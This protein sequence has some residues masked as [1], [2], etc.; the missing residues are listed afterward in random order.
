MPLFSETSMQKE[1]YQNMYDHEFS[2]W[3]YLGLDHLLLQVLKKFKP[4]TKIKILDAGCGTGRVMKRL[5]YAEVH[6]IDFSQDAIDFCKKRGLLKTQQG[7]VLSLPYP[8]EQFDV[9]ISM[10]VIYHQGIPDDRIA[11]R[12][13]NRVL[14]NHG[15]LIV[16]LPALES[17]RGVHDQQVH[18]RER[19]T[20]T[21]LKE[22]AIAEGFTPLM[23]TY[24]LFPLFPLIFLMRKIKHFFKS[25]EMPTSDIGRIPLWIN[26]LL[27]A[28]VWLENQCLKIF[29]MPIGT[30]VFMVAK[31]VEDKT[32]AREIDH[33]K[34]IKK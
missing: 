31:K 21:I 24:R 3:W 8:S 14:K 19:Y 20:T 26:Q 27:Y 5:E 7:S 13:F 4:R 17:L 1:E 28:I 25:N 22:R 6:G 11:L 30:S 23:M 9:V 12:E 2:H 10:D 33:L 15:I 32:S 18:T 16:N 29:S 34:Q